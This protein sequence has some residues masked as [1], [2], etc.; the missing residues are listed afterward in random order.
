NQYIE[1]GYSIFERYWGMGYASRTVKIACEQLYTT[2]LVKH[3][4]AW[5]AEEN[6]A[7][8][9]ALEGNGFNRTEVIESSININGE[10]YNQVYFVK[11]L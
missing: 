8:I 7:S 9:K 3:I 1:I 11:N 5:C 4:K 6:I 10:S 2:G